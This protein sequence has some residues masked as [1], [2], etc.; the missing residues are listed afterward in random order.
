[1]K[2]N[3]TVLFIAIIAFTFYNPVTLYAEES[4]SEMEEV[5]V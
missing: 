5:V 4:S 2:I 1:M 3:S